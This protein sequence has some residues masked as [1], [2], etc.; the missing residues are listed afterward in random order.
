[1]DMKG[2]IIEE[3]GPIRSAP[4]GCTWYVSQK[5]RGKSISDTDALFDTIAKAHHTYPC[6]ASMSKDREY[7]DALLHIAGYNARDAVCKA[8]GIEECKFSHEKS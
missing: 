1:V 3:I 2:D 7:G 4:C 5:V 8:T 6:T